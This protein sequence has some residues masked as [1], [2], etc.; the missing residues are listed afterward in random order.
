MKLLL[1]VLPLVVFA[2]VIFFVVRLFKRV[3]RDPKRDDSLAKGPKV[4]Y[5]LKATIYCVTGF[6]C[7]VVAQTV[8][9]D[10]GVHITVPILI[11][12][13]PYVQ[14]VGLVLWYY[15]CYVIVDGKGYKW[16]WTLI[17]LFPLVGL[18][19]LLGVKDKRNP[20]YPKLSKTK[21]ILLVSKIVF[22]VFLIITLWNAL[23]ISLTSKQKTSPENNVA[24]SNNDS[25]NKSVPAWNYL[26][27]GQNYLFAKRYEEAIPPLKE[28]IRLQPDKAAEGYLALSMAY[29]SLGRFEEAIESQQQAI[30]LQPE[31]NPAYYGLG[32]AY[33]HLKRYQEAIEP[34][35]HSIRIKP[36]NAS[37]YHYLGWAYLMLGDKSAALEVCETLKGVDP[38]EAE[39]LLKEINSKKSEAA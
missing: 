6:L 19:V 15:G 9:R 21:Y 27:K 36:D 33:V 20:D 4:K 38:K 24:S 34:L 8:I 17:G 13:A 5:G 7:L 14:A 22:S 11:F 32:V 35:K 28:A 3:E 12:L 16:F 31:D 10:A 26:R 18:L 1:S 37:T 25:I 23:V 29:L 30:R 2:L 39:K